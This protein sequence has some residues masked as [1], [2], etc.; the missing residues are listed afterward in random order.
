MTHNSL[1]QDHL[2]GIFSALGDPT[3]LG[4]VASL[5]KEDEQTL[6]SL[7]DTS[8]LTRQG[9]T[10]HLQVLEDAGVVESTRVGRERLFRL[11]P[12]PFRDMQDYLAQV[13]QRWD[14]ALLRLQSFVEE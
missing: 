11:S 2:A 5:L 13:S 10:R 8:P 3:R 7:A 14:E 12:E 6:S 4:L 1:K 9:L